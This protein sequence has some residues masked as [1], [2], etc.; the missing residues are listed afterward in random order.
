MKNL[1]ISNNIKFI[2]QVLLQSGFN[3]QIVHFKS[4]ARKRIL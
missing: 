3:S 2:I 4:A 1:F